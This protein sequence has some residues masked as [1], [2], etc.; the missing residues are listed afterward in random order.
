MKWRHTNGNIYEIIY[1]ANE[2]K[3]RTNC[4]IQ[5]R[6]WSRPLSDWERSFTKI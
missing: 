6:V 1:I 2:P 4:S 3:I 5:R